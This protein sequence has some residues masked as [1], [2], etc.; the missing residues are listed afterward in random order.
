M[1]NKLIRFYKLSNWNIITISSY[2]LLSIFL[3]TYGF[4][5][6]SSLQKI[7]FFYG[8]GTQF[9]IY[10][11]Q[12]KA[13]RNFNYFLI[14]TAIGVIHLC[15]FLTI[16]DLPELSMTNYNAGQGLRNT[17]I[18]LVLFQFL[19]FISLRTQNKEL[20]APAKGSKYDI[21]DE[22]NVT[23]IDILCFV[24]FLIVTFFFL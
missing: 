12:Y 8:F 3:L 15:L 2:L 14:W 6:K 4:A 24:V 16:K 13:L 23:I 21:L 20:V 11:F 22:R 17:L 5:N 19:R 1:Q 10:I 18:T 7:I 9:F